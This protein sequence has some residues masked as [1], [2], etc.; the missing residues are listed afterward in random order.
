VA[1][2]PIP[3]RAKEEPML[4]H[5]VRRALRACMLF[6]AV[7]AVTYV[8]FYVI[9]ANPAQLAAGKTASAERI[10]EVEEFLGLDD[11]I[12]VQ[13]VKFVKRIVFDG[14][15]GHS[16]INRQSVNDTI[17]RA[18]PVTASLVFGGM[19][20]ILLVSIP[21]GISRCSGPTT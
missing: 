12:Y 16:F 4:Q 2:V 11:P 7:A 20:L 6:L 8:I 17:L 1:N 5:L 19:V 14:S 21:I 3:R 18:A 13:Y 10:R 9:P 15:L